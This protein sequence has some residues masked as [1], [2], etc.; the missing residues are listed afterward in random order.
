[1]RGAVP[2]SVQGDRGIGDDGDPV[3]RIFPGSAQGD[4]GIGDHGLAKR[5]GYLFP[6]DG[7]NVQLDLRIRNQNELKRIH[8]LNVGYRNIFGGRVKL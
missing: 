8:R 1:M 3:R 7:R 4:R 2:G 6:I 5:T